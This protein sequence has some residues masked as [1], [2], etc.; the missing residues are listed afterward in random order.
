MNLLFACDILNFL[1]NIYFWLNTTIKNKYLDLRGYL[2][3]YPLIVDV[4]NPSL[5]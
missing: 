2:H 4:D 1:I 5:F 3:L